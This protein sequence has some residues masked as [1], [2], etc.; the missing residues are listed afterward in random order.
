LALLLVV[1]LKSME[2]FD[3]VHCAAGVISVPRVPSPQKALVPKR[4]GLGATTDVPSR[5]PSFDVFKHDLVGVL[6]HL[7][8]TSI[9]EI[10]F[11]TGV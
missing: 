9:S 7:L 11:G 6:D 3:L 2:G 4:T 5:A 8:L 1:A 10:L